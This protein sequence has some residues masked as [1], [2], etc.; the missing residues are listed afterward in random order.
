MPL[1]SGLVL[2]GEARLPGV[3][4]LLLGRPGVDSSHV[5]LRLRHTVYE[6]QA[7]SVRASLASCGDIHH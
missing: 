7:L 2:G 3:N 4:E 1:G 6:A 5:V